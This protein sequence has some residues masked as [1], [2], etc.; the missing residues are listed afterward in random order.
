MAAL[1]ERSFIIRDS[2]E[3]SKVKSECDIEGGRGSCEGGV[4]V[5][6]RLF[7]YVTLPALPHSEREEGGHHPSS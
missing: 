1:T 3:E 5:Y 4:C 6:V 7:G 2:D